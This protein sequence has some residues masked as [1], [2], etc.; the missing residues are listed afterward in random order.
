[1]DQTQQ[2]AFTV[3]ELAAR[4]NVCNRT[5]LRAIAAQRLPAFKVGGRDW[6]IR[7]ETVCAIEQQY[8]LQ[9]LR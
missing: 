9:T 7:V 5:V 6:R 8:P 2:P 3:S 4:W 1:M